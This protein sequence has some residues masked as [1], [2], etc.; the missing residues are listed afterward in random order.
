MLFI[1]FVGASA[2]ASL[3][4]LKLNS[5]RSDL[6]LIA[7]A[8]K[9]GETGLSFRSIDRAFKDTIAI[10]GA[11]K[12]DREKCRLIVISFPTSDHTL[13]TKLFRSFGAAG[14]IEFISNENRHKVT[15]LK[16]EVEDVIRRVPGSLHIIS[17]EVFAKRKTSPL[18]LPLKNFHSPLTDELKLHW[19]AN[20]GHTEIET[21]V[22]N[23]RSKF[24]SRKKSEDYAFEDDKGLWFKPAADTECHGKA[25][26]AGDSETT[27]LR[28]KFRF[29]VSVYPG[30]HYDVR[31]SK[32]RTLRASLIDA[33][34][35]E[36]ALASEKRDYINIH[37]NDILLPRK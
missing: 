10:L 8:V 37:P 29:G 31:D 2:A 20:L 12:I 14:W 17:R 36:R 11:S 6:R 16:Q 30:F 25:H 19:Y 23:F 22:A 34:H 28:G 7:P 32:G 15:K 9:K 4:L 3:Q 18:I 5:E 27:Y 1:V 24:A 26:P 13:A 35:G 21:Q 33:D